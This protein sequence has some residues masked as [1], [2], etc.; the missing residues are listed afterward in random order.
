MTKNADEKVL[1]ASNC[2]LVLSVGALII[3]G[4]IDVVPSKQASLAVIF[5]SFM[6]VVVI[7]LVVSLSIAWKRRHRE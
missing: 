3:L 4:C 2:V 1:H 5:Y 6:A 7:S